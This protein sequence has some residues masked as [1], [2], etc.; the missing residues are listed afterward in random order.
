MLTWLSLLVL[1]L[2]SGAAFV[3]GRRRATTAAAGRS[4]V[5]HSLPDYYG[6]YVALWAGVPAALLLLLGVMAGG[7]V[8]DAIL[9]SARPAAVAE[10][11]FRARGPVSTIS[12]Y[13]SL[14][15][16]PSSE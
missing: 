3:A 11:T 8:E 10:Y 13:P 14:S 1:A 2:F 5:L 4:R 9:Q 7:R 16:F 15:S 6:T 12:M